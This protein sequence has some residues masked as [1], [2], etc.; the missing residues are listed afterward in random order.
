MAHA[1]ASQTAAASA[2]ILYLKRNNCRFT[3]KRR[4]KKRPVVLAWSSVLFLLP[5]SWVEGWRSQCHSIT[6]PVPTAPLSVPEKVMGGG[7]WKAK[8]E[9]EETQRTNSTGNF[10]ESM[11]QWS[12]HLKKSPELPPTLSYCI[13]HCIVFNHYS[14]TMTCNNLLPQLHLAFAWQ[15]LIKIELLGLQN[16]HLIKAECF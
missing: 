14:G 12:K 13:S 1:W 6:F 11:K 5:L 8:D 9:S 16:K 3:E 15:S 7:C 2:P 4:E 10:L